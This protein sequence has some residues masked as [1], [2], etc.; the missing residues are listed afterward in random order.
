MAKSKIENA[1]PGTSASGVAPSVFNSRF[2]GSGLMVERGAGNAV[3]LPSTFRP[4]DESVVMLTGKTRSLARFLNVMV[5]KRAPGLWAGVIG[6]PKSKVEHLAEMAVDSDA[7]AE[8]AMSFAD[9]GLMRNINDR[10]LR[11]NQRYKSGVFTIDYPALLRAVAGAVGASA[12]VKDT[13]WIVA[14]VIAELLS[15]AYAKLNVMVPFVGAAEMSWHLRPVVMLDDLIRASHVSVI[16]EVFEAIEL[17]SGFDASK[18]FNPAVAEAMIGP[19]LT[20]ASNRLMN[21]LRYDKYMRDTAVLTGQH[22]ACPGLLPEHLQDNP[23]LQ[24]LAANASFALDAI[25]KARNSISTPDFDLRDAIQY[26]V[27][28]LREMKR[29]ETWSME[30]FASYYS[31]EL[32]RAQSGYVAGVVVQRHDPFKINGQVTRFVERGDVVMQLQSNVGEAYVSPLTEAVNRAFEGGVLQRHLSVAA[33]HLIVNAFQIDG[34]DVGGYAFTAGLTAD[35]ERILGLAHAKFLTLI[36]IEEDD[37]TS[38]PTIVMEVPDLKMFYNSKGQPTGTGF[39]TTDPMEVLILNGVEKADPIPFTLRPQTILDDIRRVVLTSIPETFRVDGVDIDGLIDLSKPVKLNLPMLG[40]SPVSRTESLQDLLGLIEVGPLH[41]TVEQAAYQSLSTTLAAFV[42]I[43]NDLRGSGPAGALLARQVAIA[44]HALIGR[45]VSHSAF[46]P[47]VRTVLRRFVT[48]PAFTG[49]HLALR[50]HLQEAFVR[51]QLA[52]N[53]GFM[54]LLKLGVL[55][56]GVHEDLTKMFEAENVVEVAVTAE[57][58]Q[59][60]LNMR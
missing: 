28:R 19:L 23:D 17:G 10:L 43:Y 2:I 29:F 48:D 25:D 20:A 15:R 5:D 50:A 58:W 11:G 45:V 21:A 36:G 1:Q 31:I 42:A 27:M 39:M 41:L 47:L 6:G 49:R 40:D 33:Q 37:I 59:A 13:K 46:Q 53:T 54:I 18:E 52:L 60:A 26:T 3:M 30:R 16:T 9:V 56:F 34:S 38:T 44:A 8:I 12:S 22:I 57:S 7:V 32:V 4:I 24:Y 51:H 55:E 14:R 35:E